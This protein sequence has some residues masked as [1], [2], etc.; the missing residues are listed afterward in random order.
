ML[1]AKPLTVITLSFVITVRI[2]LKHLQ[3]SLWKTTLTSDYLSTRTDILKY[4]G[5]FVYSL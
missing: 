3:T 4:W 1:I 2:L 5:H